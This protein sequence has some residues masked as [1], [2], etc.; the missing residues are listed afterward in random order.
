[1]QIL[2]EQ[3]DIFGREWQACFQDCFINTHNNS[4][5]MSFVT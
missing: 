1:M 2:R 3:L 4:I 5:Y